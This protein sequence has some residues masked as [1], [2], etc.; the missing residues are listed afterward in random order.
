MV[1]EKQVKGYLIKAKDSTV[2]YTVAEYFNFIE[3]RLGLKSP[4]DREAYRGTGIFATSICS[5]RDIVVKTK[6]HP[7]FKSINA[8]PEK[9]L[10]EHIFGE[11]YPDLFPEY[12][13]YLGNRFPLAI[14]DWMD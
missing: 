4:K 7:E 2:Y 14:K 13:K 8:Y 1:K 10:A 9:V 3:K 12:S 6:P 11:G 5:D